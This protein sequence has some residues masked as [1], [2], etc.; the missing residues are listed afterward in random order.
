MK[1]YA[2]AFGALLSLLSATTSFAATK[3]DDARAFF[4]RF[5]AAQNAHDLTQIKAM[6][7][8][9]PKMLWYARG[10]ANWGP[11]AVVSKL[12]VYYQGAW[13]LK[14][15]MSHFSVVLVADN[16]AQL[17]VPITFTR[18]HAGET[19]TD[20]TFLISQT[21]VMGKDGWRVASIMPIADTNFK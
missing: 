6:L 12:K 17:M 15:D 14:P 1:P 2:L 7:W 19:P 8:D 10:G 18:S 4:T 9:S 5:V 16:V 20:S 3:E 21:L 11:D 13:Q